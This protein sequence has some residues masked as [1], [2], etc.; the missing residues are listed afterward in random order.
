MAGCPGGGDG[1]TMIDDDSTLSLPFA[2]YIL[3]SQSGRDDDEEEESEGPMD[4]CLWT[5]ESE[6]ERLALLGSAA[7]D[8]V[9]GI[10]WSPRRSTSSE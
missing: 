3:L 9:L 8:S 5:T 10:G 7:D 4:R 1:W 6:L 2:V